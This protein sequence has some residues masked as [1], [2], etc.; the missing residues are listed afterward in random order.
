MTS[1]PVS[2][3][4]VAL[5]STTILKSELPAVTV[6]HT[7]NNSSYTCLSDLEVGLFLVH[8]LCG[9]VAF[10]LEF[11]CAST[12]LFHEPVNSL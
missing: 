2:I 1:F 3:V 12:F 6:T 5:Q 10:Y 9:A 11:D 4:V 8:F 7:I